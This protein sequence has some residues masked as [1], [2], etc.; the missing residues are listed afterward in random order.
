MSTWSLGSVFGGDKARRSETPVSMS[1]MHT[2]A[3]SFRD[4]YL[5]FH[6]Y[7]HVYIH[8]YIQYT[9]DSGPK[10]TSHADTGKDAYSAHRHRAS[11]TYSHT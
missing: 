2:W 6:A 1:G 7:I 3:T 9:Y 5:S 4:A 11:S 10:H 8:V